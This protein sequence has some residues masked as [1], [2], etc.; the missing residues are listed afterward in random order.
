MTQPTEY[1]VNLPKTDFPMKADLAKRE[2]KMLE[3]WQFI[4]LYKKIS[5]AEG[6]GREKFILHDGP[7]YA[8]GAIHLGHAANKTLKDIVLKSKMLSGFS[9]PYVPGW[10]CHGLPI[11]LNVEKKIGRVGSKVSAEEFLR[12][13]RKYAL[14]QIDS[15]RKDF[16]RLGVLGDWENPYKTL[17]FSFEANTI[18]ELGKII[19]KGYLERGFK[20]VH[21]CVACGSALAEAEVEY[22]EKTSPAI[23]VS[24]NLV[25]PELFEL[26]ELSIPIW[27]TTPWTLPANEA[28][29]LHP[30]LDYVLVF[31]PSLNRHFVVLEALLDATMGRLGEKKPKIKNKLKGKAFK[32]VLLEH[33]FL[34]KR[35]PV[36]L[37]EHVT[38]DT[39]TGAV[40]TA[41]AHGQEDFAIGKE[42][43]LPVKNPV[44]PDG[45]FLSDTEFFAGLNV[46]DANEKVIEKLRE[47]NNL[48]HAETIKHSYPH[49]WR[50]KTP[51][52]FRA[53][54]QWF[55]AMDKPAT[56]GITLRKKALA[57]IEDVKW[58]PDRGKD[59]IKEMIQNR[60]D[61]CI[62]R[63]R[64][65]GTPITLF[66]R[67]SNGEL[68][69][70]TQR[71]IAIITDKIEKEGL[72]YWLKIKTE[73]FLREFA[74]N[75]NADD[76]E[77][78]K[79]TLD[80]WFDAGV[81]HY[82]VL[83]KRPELRFP[84]DLYLEGSDQYRGWFQS[85]LLTSV[86]I[87]GISPYKQNVCHGFAVDAHGHKMSKSLG[88]VI[89]PQKVIEKYGADV[90]RLWIASTYPFDDF[91]IS[92][93][94][95]LRN[96]DAYRIFRNTAR[97]LL[98][99]LMDFNSETDLLSSSEMIEL[100]RW[101][102]MKIIE[103][104][105]NFRKDYENYE[106]HTSCGNLQAILATEMSGFYFSVIKDRLYTMAP[107]SKGR[108]SAQTA[109][110]HILEM[111]VRMMAPICSFTAEEI[112]QE[113][114]KISPQRKESVFLE[115]WYEVLQKNELSNLKI[116]NDEWNK[117]I[118]IRY[119]VNKKLEELRVAGK[120]GSSLAAEINLYCDADTKYLFDKFQNPQGNELRFV[121]I[122][123]TAD[124]K[125]LD[126]APASAFITDISGLKLEVHPSEHK[127]C[128]RCWHYRNDVGANN[129]HPELCSRCVENLF[130]EGEIRLFA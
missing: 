99:N 68:H 53:T 61:W 120:I 30:D 40:H 45:K 27:T 41:P 21:W 19:A 89:A 117:I 48:L 106:F 122:T 77:K 51:L 69:P 104:Q 25:N 36:I 63:Q 125:D 62:S 31:C 55:I 112:W 60:P 105:A 109:L 116:S 34:K 91:P 107:G 126:L 87:N 20:P 58:F 6:E 39:G 10:D 82:C 75:Y 101:A 130:G 67:K 86:A 5:G 111:L 94:I 23:D 38:V 85:S 81:T 113:M 65:Y 80:V 50:H 16:I 79:D 93:E 123:S 110:F 119:E 42:N 43:N 3:F 8:N 4:D 14:E 54:Q 1:K 64:V 37:G 97:F 115:K 108:R 129:E 103:Q 24:F 32:G 90:L 57:V 7:P 52:I 102:L 17:D 70:E 35:V 11:E 18:R 74:P 13:C 26:S 49:C 2:P 83:E 15:Q 124:I 56:D 33:P 22:Q 84:A 66:V 29:C 121:L 96:V 9:T 76:F 88:N 114:K 95:L 98:G 71:L 47:K 118:A 12:A 73:D 127:K 100:D 44:G 28:V 92:D 128:C 72:E 78:V 59:R 46:F